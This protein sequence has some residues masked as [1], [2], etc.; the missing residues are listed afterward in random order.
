MRPLR[1]IAGY[2]Y[3]AVEPTAAVLMEPPLTPTLSPQVAQAGRGQ[4]C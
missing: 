1:L 4:P 3:S 2:T